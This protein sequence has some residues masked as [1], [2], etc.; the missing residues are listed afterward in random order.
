MT[1]SP[2]LFVYREPGAK[3]N[4]EVYISFVI[5]DAIEVEKSQYNNSSTHTMRAANLGETFEPN[6]GIVVN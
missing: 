1:I 4:S 6:R 3:Y 5:G 2:A